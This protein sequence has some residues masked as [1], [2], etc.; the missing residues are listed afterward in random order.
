MDIFDVLAAIDEFGKKVDS[1]IDK[2]IVNLN[3]T[4]KIKDNGD[5]YS[6]KVDLPGFEKE[7]ISIDI[8]ENTLNLKA[9]NVA[10]GKKSLVFYIPKDINQGAITSSLKN[11]QL[12]IVLPKIKKVTPTTLKIRIM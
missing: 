3:Y 2:A 4:S 6:I 12:T 11:G 1:N 9:M 7:E 5:Y 8:V 10:E